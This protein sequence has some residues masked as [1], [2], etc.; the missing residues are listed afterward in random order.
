MSGF[1]GI[2]SPTK[3]S[4]DLEAFEQMRKTSALDGFD[5]MQIHVEDHIAMGHLMLRVSPES[6]Y[7]Q[8]PLKSSC[9][10]Y[11][12]VG[13][14]RLDYRDELGDKLGLVQ[15]EL[16]KTPDSLLVMMA[17]QKW[18][19]KCVNH[20]EGDWAFAL[21]NLEKN[22]L[23]L[24]KDQTGHSAIYYR[25][26]QG[27]LYFSSASKV[28]YNV[29]GLWVK[30]DNLRLQAYLE[31]DFL[32]ASG[33]TFVQNIFYIRC[34]HYILFNSSL[35]FI[36][37]NY[38]QVQ[39]ATTKFKFEDDYIHSLH[40]F[41]SLA[42][43]SRSISFFDLGIF[44]SSGLDSSA[45]TYYLA[46]ELLIQKKL[47]RTY[48]SYPFYLDHIANEEH[49]KINEAPFVEKFV[50]QFQ[51]IESS[52]MSF[53]DLDVLSKVEK[54]SEDLG[55][56][57]TTINTFWISGILDVAKRNRLARVLN[58]QMGNSIISWD[59]SMLLSSLMLRFKILT[60][61]KQLTDISRIHKK[62][63]FIIFHQFV[64][65]DFIRFFITKKRYFKFKYLDKI[66]NLSIYENIQS[67]KV[68]YGFG[69]ISLLKDQYAF[70]FDSK[71]MRL[72]Q[73]FSTVEFAGM[74]WYHNGHSFA[75]ETSDPTTDLRLVNYSF[76]L[77]DQLFISGGLKKY[78]YKRWMGI[79]LTKEILEKKYRIMQ[80]AD[81]GIR[82]SKSELARLISN[83]L[84]SDDS[85][86]HIGFKSAFIDLLGKLNA[87]KDF[88]KKRAI[89][90]QFLKQ[91]SV[92]I[93]LRSNKIIA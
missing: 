9:G 16:E 53:P 44:L 47:L 83:D 92:H 41:F 17:F 26:E 29:N 76:S 13:H 37:S 36:E 49:I 18:K 89:A 52:L 3:K 48:T 43:K 71:K 50:Q 21:V 28:L 66:Q 57:F 33:Y 46:N 56:P 64:L 39:R 75:I 79:N 81:F 88:R 4:I 15:S 5:G 23:F 80:S 67:E 20:L 91:I 70:Y 27:V 86:N 59:G 12:L 68:D 72:R 8:Q 11:M 14:F 38:W 54:S 31:Y 73:F 10:N 87:E 45:V 35:S 7:D 58:G 24:A 55:Y 61:V 25:K 30:I 82:L 34:A 78:I 60:L 93:L 69:E 65:I 90:A 2:F 40:T 6:Q 32:P 62:N 19:E 22:D 85:K 74:R 77:P 84:G 51:N 63:I 1:F 42:V